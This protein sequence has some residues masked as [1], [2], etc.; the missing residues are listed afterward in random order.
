MTDNK[1]FTTTRYPFPIPPNRTNGIIAA[2]PISPV[3]YLL[4]IIKSG[5][6]NIAELRTAVGQITQ[7]DW[8]SRDDILRVLGPNRDKRAYPYDYFA[9]EPQPGRLVHQ[10]VNAGRYV[11]P[12]VNQQQCGCCW[13]CATTTMVSVRRAIVQD[14]DNCNGQEMFSIPELNTCSNANNSDSASSTGR[15]NFSSPGAPLS[16]TG[17]LDPNLLGGCGGGMPCAAA[18]WIQLNG[19][20]KSAGPYAYDNNNACSVST[21]CSRTVPLRPASFSVDPCSKSNSC[22][23][24]ACSTNE[25]AKCYPV[26]PNSVATVEGQ[27]YNVSAVFNYVSYYEIEPGTGKL[28][29]VEPKLNADG[30]DFA[31]PKPSR[32][33]IQE[34]MKLHLLAHGPFVIA[35]AA[36]GS[37]FQS[38]QSGV[39]IASQDPGP[40]DHAVTLVGWGQTNDNPPIP[41]LRIKNSWSG[42]TSCTDQGS[43]GWGENGYFRIAMSTDTR[44]QTMGVDYPVIQNGTISGGGTGA[45]VRGMLPI[46]LP[47]TELPGSASL[48]VSLTP[49]GAETSH[50]VAEYIPTRAGQSVHRSVLAGAL[51]SDATSLVPVSSS[52]TAPQSQQ[53]LN[54]RTIDTPNSWQGPTIISLLS[55]ILAAAII[56]LILL[57]VRR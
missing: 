15:S 5:V 6:A 44:N 34:F 49:I 42:Q 28:I 56:G 27:T 30:S 29:L 3:A 11:G 46:D 26:S 7:F 43:S 12:V 53:S 48:G 47:P 14:L 45:L 55:L 16:L 4:N 9:Y 54:D 36:S 19:I 35:F 37:E 57:A 10:F 33:S 50:T 8:T 39:F 1:T 22:N 20:H 32:Q 18:N 21:P 38:Y 24:Q 31:E 52:L 25:A 51:P 40:V 41:Y 17:C 13:A 23:A 2:P